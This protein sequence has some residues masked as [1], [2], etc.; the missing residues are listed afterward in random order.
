MAFTP[1]DLTRETI[2]ALF[3]GGPQADN[4][5]GGG[6]DDQID[7]KGGD[8]V[9]FGAGGDDLLL[10]GDGDDVLIGGLGNDILRGQ[11]GI[12]L[13]D[14][15][16]INGPVRFDIL[17]PSTL[18]N[19]PGGERDTAISVEIL[20]SS[21]QNDVFR[22]FSD[23]GLKIFAF[24]GE[25]G[26][27]TLDMSAL[28][29]GAFFD[30]SNLEVLFGDDDFII[31]DSIEKIIGTSGDDLIAGGVFFLDFNGDDGFDTVG[32]LDG[33]E[34]A[35]VNLE[36]GTMEGAAVGDVVRNV[37][38]VIGTAFD[39]ELT[40]DANDNALFG[41][42]GSDLL[43]GGGGDDLLDGG[44][45]LDAVGYSSSTG[46]VRANMTN[47]RVID[48][49]GS[50]D[51]LVSIERIT[52]SSFSDTLVGGDVRNVMIGGDGNDRLDGRGGNDTMAGGDGNDIYTVKDAG[53]QVIE[54]A[55]EGDKDRIN[56]YVD[57]TSPEN[58]EYL[59][60]VFSSVGLELTGNEGRDRI[61]G[62]NLIRASDQINGRGGNDFIA[63]LV[64]D[65]DIMGGA[66]RDR[67][68]GN[69]GDDVINGGADNDKMTGQ[70]GADTFVFDLNSGVD[71]ITDF[72]PGLDR[73]DVSAYGIADF[74]ALA[75]IA[76][77]IGGRAVISL[78]GN[79]DFV[80]LNGVLEADLSAGDFIFS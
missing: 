68:F 31:L 58:N 78:N 2:A 30:V 14:Y 38:G 66:G 46:A 64:G 70:Y 11:D 33:Q 76:D 43:I 48:A 44:A 39:D 9:L 12:D 21:K 73:I 40:G 29:T 25:A 69:S 56:V 7:G 55:G 53:D 75:A 57:F 79:T 28:S 72:T 45:G 65:D 36:T 27:D 77:D 60:G 74:A 49:D 19:L 59:V 42:A 16:H 35:I 5:D 1:V 26:V 24:L 63:G 6:S 15:N 3:S 47:G 32:Y 23:N 52:G 18:I 4:L 62:S 37:E 51:T 13:A 50:I 71:M 17:G 22:V 20:I 34:A 61:S 67:L 54:K 8:D 80:R 10:G 41:D